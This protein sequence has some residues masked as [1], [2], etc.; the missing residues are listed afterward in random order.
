MEIEGEEGFKYINEYIDSATERGKALRKRISDKFKFD[1]LEFQSLKGIVEA[2]GIDE[3][4][5][6]TYCWT[7]KED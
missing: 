2:I 3:D 4:K 7:G 6:C 5:L 1:S